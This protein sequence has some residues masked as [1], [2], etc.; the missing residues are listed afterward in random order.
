MTTSRN[1]PAPA[2]LPPSALLIPSQC[3]RNSRT[4]EFG[5]RD[6]R[7]SRVF[8]CG[9][10]RIGLH[11]FFA[12]DDLGVPSELQQCLIPLIFPS[13][14]RNRH[15]NY[16]TLKGSTN[17]RGDYTYLQIWRRQSSSRHSFWSILSR[18]ESNSTPNVST[19]Y[20]QKSPTS[21]QN[22]A[23]ILS[24]AETHSPPSTSTR[25]WWLW[26]AYI[27]PLQPLSQGWALHL[28]FCKH[29]SRSHAS[30]LEKTQRRYGM[31]QWWNAQ[32]S[33]VFFSFTHAH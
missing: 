22:P 33:A 23:E 14:F 7:H 28:R 3:L 2:I 24:T 18:F 27:N 17:V 21:P 26:F 11:Q 12:F 1:L 15:D 29:F 4:R 10:F 30:F 25:T 31:I 9:I 20:K 19:P 32:S 8:E 5:G 13:N 6:T 16:G